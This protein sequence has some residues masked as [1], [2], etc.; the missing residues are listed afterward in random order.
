MKSRVISW[1]CW[2]SSPQEHS[3]SYSCYITAEG[4]SLDRDAPLDG[5]PK[6]QKVRRLYRRKAK[7]S[8]CDYVSPGCVETEYQEGGT[9]AR[10]RTRRQN[11]KIGGWINQVISCC[12]FLLYLEQIPNWSSFKG[13][14]TENTTKVS[15]NY[16]SFKGIWL[17]TEKE[18]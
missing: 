13:K 8:K 9:V 18:N 17:E 14:R 16:Y 3:G 5:D 11:L 6:G 12:C 1:T 7:K 2:F 15:I 4:F 10:R